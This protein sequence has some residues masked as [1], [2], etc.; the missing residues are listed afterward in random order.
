MG[1]NYHSWFYANGIC[2]Q[3]II[4]LPCH[5]GEHFVLILCTISS[6]LTLSL[7]RKMKEASLSCF[8]AP[9][10][11]PQNLSFSERATWPCVEPEENISERLCGTGWS[12]TLKLVSISMSEPCSVRGFDLCLVLGS[13]EKVKAL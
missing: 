2:L 1:Y 5:I 6:G 3:G 13:F 7:Q 12:H 8:P 4:A 11:L 9:V 10:L